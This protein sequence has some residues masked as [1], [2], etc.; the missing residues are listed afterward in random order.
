MKYITCF[1]TKTLNI[2]PR[3]FSKY[4]YQHRQFV[5]KYPLKYHS[6]KEVNAKGSYESASQI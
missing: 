3:L 5:L 1:N 4:H 2:W 6:R